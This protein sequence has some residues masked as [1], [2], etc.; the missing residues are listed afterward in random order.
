[1]CVWTVISYI[2]SIYSS[3]SNPYICNGFNQYLC[4][5]ALTHY[6]FCRRRVSTSLASDFC[7]KM[8]QLI[9]SF[10]HRQGQQQYHDS[11][12][13]TDYYEEQP[14]WRSN[15]ELQNNDL[16]ASASSSLVPLSYQTFSNPNSQ[17]HASLTP[18]VPQNLLVS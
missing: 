1:M 5:L 3:D 18:H 7:G 2:S 4:M 6:L 14:F 11:N 9:L 13:F 15:D 12:N 17:R 16:V 8:N 10:L